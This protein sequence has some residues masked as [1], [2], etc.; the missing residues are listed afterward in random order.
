MDENAVVRKDY[1]N[2]QNRLLNNDVNADVA[3]SEATNLLEKVHR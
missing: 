1:H 2:L 3:L